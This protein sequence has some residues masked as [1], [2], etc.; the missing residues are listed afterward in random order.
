MKTFV[1]TLPDMAKEDI[2]VKHYGAHE[3]CE[4]GL[5]TSAS[6]TVHIQQHE[7]QI[8]LLPV[9]GDADDDLADADVLLMNAA[10]FF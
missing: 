9:A 5:G 2:L 10:A 6:V 4:I 3:G 1:A 8:G 7:L